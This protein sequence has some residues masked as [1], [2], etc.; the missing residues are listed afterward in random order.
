MDNKTMIV[1]SEIIW[2]DEETISIDEINEIEERD[3]E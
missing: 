2:I 3:N 1:K